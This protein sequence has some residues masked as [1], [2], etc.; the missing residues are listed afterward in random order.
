VTGHIAADY[1]LLAGI[2]TTF[3]PSCE[4]R[5]PTVLACFL[6]TIRFEQACL[7]GLVIY[8]NLSNVWQLLT[9]LQQQSHPPR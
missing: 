4:A 1:E 7:A 5:D 6:M 8:A 9:A 3:D 2:D